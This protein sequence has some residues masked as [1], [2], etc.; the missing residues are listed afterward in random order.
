[1]SLKNDA[2]VKVPE[3]WYSVMGT[4]IRGTIP[5]HQD[6]IVSLMQTGTEKDYTQTQ[7]INYISLW[8]KISATVFM[9][10]IIIFYGIFTLFF[11][12]V[13]ISLIEKNNLVSSDHKILNNKVKV[14]EA[15]ATLYN[16]DSVK[17]LTILEKKTSWETKI[18]FVFDLAKKNQINILKIFISN[19]SKTVT[20]QGSSP[21]QN[22]ISNFKDDLE[23]TKTFHNVTSPLE[24]ISSDG[25]NYYFS[26]KFNL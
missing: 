1:M 19:E 9:A 17:L 26:I 7:A 20:L 12:P 23:G 5:R 10:L 8:T 6:K 16:S 24:S 3:E 13:E 25:D 11:K 4:A 21:S 15:K 18:D 14:L 22:Q 2:L